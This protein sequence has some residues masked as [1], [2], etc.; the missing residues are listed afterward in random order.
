MCMQVNSKR[1]QVKELTHSTGN[2]TQPKVL[3]AVLSENKEIDEIRKGISYICK[4]NSN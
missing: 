4:L 1:H 3:P 2:S